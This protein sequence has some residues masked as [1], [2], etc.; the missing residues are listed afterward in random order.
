MTFAVA[1][2]FQ[3]AKRTAPMI[4]AALAA[5]EANVALVAT[6]PRGQTGYW[7][8]EAQSGALV[9]GLAVA[10]LLAWG[11]RPQ[12]P[13]ARDIL[14]AL[15]ATGVMALALWPLRGLEPNVAVLAAQTSIG[16]AIYGALA[17]LFDIARMRERV[18]ALIGSSAAATAAASIK[19]S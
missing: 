5:I 15:A 10:L 3:I 9:V 17:W 12:W 14:G 18:K 19:N 13:R 11:T 1:P 16:V 8:A 2:I 4:L 6:M 7:L